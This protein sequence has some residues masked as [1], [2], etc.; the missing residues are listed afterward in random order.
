MIGLSDDRC[1]TAAPVFGHEISH[2]F[3]NDRDKF[4]KSNNIFPWGLGDHIPGLDVR[5]LLASPRE[6]NLQDDQLLQQSG[7]QIQG[8]PTGRTEKKGAANAAR[9]LREKRF[10]IAAIGDDSQ[11]CCFV[12]QHQ[13]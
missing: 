4:D 13:C 2:N 8:V 6:G 11:E 1:A 9:V 3:G 12:L 7:G 10:A 5:T